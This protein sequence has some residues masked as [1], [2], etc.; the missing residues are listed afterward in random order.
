MVFQGPFELY[1]D[2]MNRLLQLASRIFTDA[3]ATLP[4]IRPLAYEIVNKCFQEAILPH[5]NQ[6]GLGD[7]IRLCKGIDQA[8][9]PP[10]L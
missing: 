5:W 3:D 1:S 10:G 4:V 8:H 7:Y 9:I 2:F 6:G